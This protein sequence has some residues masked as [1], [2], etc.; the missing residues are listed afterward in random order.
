[1][2]F[3]YSL[4]WH[5]VVAG[6]LLPNIIWSNGMLTT[7]VAVFGTTISPYLFFWQASQD[8]EEMRRKEKKP[9][10]DAPAAAKSEFKRLKLDTVIGM[11]FSNLIAFFI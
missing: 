2:Q 9:L 10:I 11:T 1:M 8:V 4:P 5:E 6:T 7:I 3:G